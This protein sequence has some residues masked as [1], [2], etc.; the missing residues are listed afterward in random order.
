MDTKVDR[1]LLFSSGV[2]LFIFLSMVHMTWTKSKGEKWRKKQLVLTLLLVNRDQWVYRCGWQHYLITMVI[3]LLKHPTFL[4][5]VSLTQER[6]AL[7]HSPGR[8]E[9]PLVY[10]TVRSQLAVATLVL[11]HKSS[12]FQP[13]FGHP[14]LNHC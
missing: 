6:S 5:L 13:I 2:Y 14:P 12:G 1:L 8:L 9:W 3:N 10:S 7:L 11:S 4:P